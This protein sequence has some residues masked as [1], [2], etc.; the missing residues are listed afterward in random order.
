M[1]LPGCTFLYGHYAAQPQ[2][3]TANPATRVSFVQLNSNTAACGLLPLPSGPRLFSRTRLFE[4]CAPHTKQGTEPIGKG[5]A[6]LVGSGHGQQGTLTTTC[7][8]L[9]PDG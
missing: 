8:T 7:A 4:G 6:M 5:L 9:E 3:P 2:C 1:W